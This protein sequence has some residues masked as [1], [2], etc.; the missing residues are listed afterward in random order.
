[1]SKK[2]FTLIEIIMV[3]VIMGIS[4]LGL[5]TVMQ[6]V[7]F[8]V[9]KPQVMQVA[10]GLAEEEAERVLNL[11]FASVANEH[12]GAPASFGGNFSAYSSEIRVN[13]LD[14]NNKVVEIRVYHVALGYVWLAFL[15]T[16]Y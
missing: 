9:H 13:S 6:Q 3:I 11:E 7:L 12:F 16:N 2:G 4:S 5:V 15:K 8:N 1:M 10:I 14:S